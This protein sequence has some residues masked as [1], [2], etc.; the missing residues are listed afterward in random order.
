MIDDILDV[1][2]VAATVFVLGATAPWL[3][4]ALILA[5]VAV[6]LIT[7]FSPAFFANTLGR[8]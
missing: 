5:P 6:V 7:F 8:L 4:V 3:L 2:L 1:L